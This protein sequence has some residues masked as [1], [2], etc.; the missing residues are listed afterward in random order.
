MS[1]HSKKLNARHEKCR[2]KSRAV[3]REKVLERYSFD[4]AAQKV[5]SIAAQI[6]IFLDANEIYC[7]HVFAACAI[8]EPEV[9]HKLLGRRVTKL[10]AK[11]DLGLEDETDIE[12]ASLEEV[13]FS[14]EF[15]S[16]FLDTVP[17]T[18]FQFSMDYF[19]GKQ[20]GIAE[21]AFALMMEAT[22]EIADILIENGFSNDGNI[23]NSLLR[24]NYLKNLHSFSPLT[25][26]ERRKIAVDKADLFEEYMNLDVS[27]QELA[28]SRLASGLTDF[29]CKGNRGK[30][31]VILLLSKNGGGRSYF[32]ERMQH[33]FVEM[34]LQERIE[35]PMDMSSFVNRESCEVDLLG[36]A[37]SYKCAKSGMLSKMIRENKRGILVFEDIL[38]G[39]RNAT[40]ILRAFTQNLAIDKFEEEA[41]I[42]PLNVIV[43]TMRLTDEEYGF[44]SE[45]NDKELD[46]ALLNS[47]LL[48]KDRNGKVNEDASN[49]SLLWQRADSI[50]L[51]KQLNEGELE[52]MATRK[53]E[54]L[55]RTIRDD[56]GIELKC[57]DIPGL[58]RLVMQSS[59]EE[60]CPRK[61]HDAI[62]GMVHEK[63]LWENIRR[64]P[65]LKEF[66]VVIPQ[67]PAYPHAPE[68][69][70][71]RGD[72]LDFTKSEEIDGTTLRL[73]FSDIHYKQR[74][75]IDC[76]DY[77]IEHPKGTTFTD[78]FG[79]DDVRDELL[80]AL[81]YITG[82]D[83]YRETMPAP[84]LNFILYGP[85]GT[86]KT[87]MAVALANSADIPVFFATSSIFADTTKLSDMFRKANEMAPAIVVLE[88]FNSIG[89]ASREPW[90]R[91]AINELLA[92][93]DG[94]QE[95][96][97]LLVL[98]STNYLDQIEGALR[99]TGRFG[100]QIKI[101]LPVMEARERFIRSFETKYNFTLDDTVRS[102]F[103]DATAG[104]NF[105]D[106]KG[107]LEFALRRSIRAK[108]PL[109][110][111]LLEA[112]LREFQVA[113]NSRMVI[114]FGAEMGI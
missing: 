70:I 76:A 78:I 88:E 64:N 13:D 27:G 47:V 71:A 57:N 87:S 60:L 26:E 50:I 33:A 19:P 15:A 62:D 22:E 36:D 106:L 77:R 39:C 37:K 100:R 112:A 5:F 86:G 8:A 56:F 66:E 92:I 16:I 45:K 55:V 18:P 4:D 110:A 99:R 54:T 68:R 46:A 65:G 98:A 23:L 1:K 63:S 103:V 79:L 21:V 102:N 11:F 48:R 7:S 44:I 107:V 75:R 113:K 105:A 17:G 97:K 3:R 85:P 38:D 72:Y 90:K 34:E 29:W 84:C 6:A 10:P 109:D 95:Q 25:Q 82:S 91:D 51:L 42:L 24:E 41:L 30:P 49:C 94:V 114:G 58:V 93:L 73:T 43:L 40:H 14:S 31:Y 104:I 35:P 101:D 53:V 69:R 96:G 67:F 59:H 89:D 61:L 9:L 52:K 83:Q 80:D 28:I 108:K 32:A 2:P 74:D 20:I 81:D 12:D 111:E